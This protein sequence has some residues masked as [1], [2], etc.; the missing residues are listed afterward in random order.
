[1][2][3]HA[4]AL[5]TAYLFPSCPCGSRWVVPFGSRCHLPYLDVHR[6]EVA[7]LENFLLFC[8]HCGQLGDEMKG[9]NCVI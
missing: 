6:F 5:P 2:L 9:S 7:L 3:R 4:L 8:V 1:M